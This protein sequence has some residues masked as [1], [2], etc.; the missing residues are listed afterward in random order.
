M[1]FMTPWLLAGASLAAIPVVLHLVMRQQP[2]HFEFPALRFVQQRQ[3]TNRRK[4]KL[5]HLIL[6]LLR[7]AAVALLAM[8]LARPSLKSTGV[9]GGQEAPVAAALV[10]DT[11]P[12]MDYK[13]ENQTRLQAARDIGGWLMKEL[14]PESRV[15]V[16]DSGRSL[17]VF[18]VDLGSA[19]E[20]IGRLETT[21]VGQPLWEVLEGAAELLAHNE[22]DGEELPKRK[23]LYVFTDLTEAS[24]DAE[25][26]KALRER[27]AK[28]AGL[29]IYVIDVGVAEPKNFAL[30]EIRLSGE[31]LPRNRH[32]TLGTELSSIGQE[33]QKAVEV[34]L[35]DEQGK[36]EK[37]AQQSLDARPGESHSIEFPLGGL[38]TGA[39]QGYVRLVGTD[40]LECDN[41]RYFTVEVMPAWKVLVVAAPPADDRASSLTQALAPTAWRK[42]GQARFDCKVIGYS[43]LASEPLE[44]MAA[45]A[46]LDPGSLDD[47]VW[48]QLHA[49][50]QAGG[51]LAI[52]LGPAAQP[53]YFNTPKPQLLLPG[54]LGRL[55]ARYPGGEMYL[56]TDRS[57]H[58]MTAKFAPLAGNVP[59]EMLPVYMYWQLPKLNQGAAT[60]IAYRNNKPA[61]LERPVGKGRVATMTTPISE[62]PG[63]SEN[64]R[65]NRLAT[66]LDNWPFVMLLDQM[67]SYLAG[68]S[69]GQLNY[70]A[71]ETVVLP[72]GPEQGVSTYLLTTPRGDSFRQT[73]DDKQQAIVVPNTDRLGNYRIKAGGETQ[74]LN[75]GFSVNL[76]AAASNLARL[77]EA[78]LKDVF[79]ETEFRLAHSREEIDRDVSAGR[80]GQELFPYLILLIAVILGCEQLL[81]NRF[82]RES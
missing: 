36:A 12:R 7:M 43:E 68:S 24:W 54:E 3:D 40:G 28:L 5:R 33:G 44:G 21:P 63:T 56:S 37:R 15:A 72:L 77:D 69:A 64:N 17:P 42:T 62:S 49:F 11:S 58:P 48:E 73:V 51:G 32:W 30:G 76:S 1:E 13:S 53:E 60:V 65:W 46:L 9:I 8:A 22:I 4:L 34:Y 67:F 27:L 16:L 66:G 80:V 71:G 19:Q 57:Q 6:L 26:S 50:A 55:P 10:F 18:Q 29:G 78:K 31:I 79:G 35:I 25:S 74:G 59:W 70:L 41:R 39:H 61:V 45:V 23:E 82:Y 81:A 47:V 38:E 14:P 75:R 2:K 52:F 20:R